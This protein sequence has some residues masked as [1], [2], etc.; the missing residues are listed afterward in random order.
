MVTRNEYIVSLLNLQRE[1]SPDLPLTMPI[2][3]LVHT[4]LQNL[5]LISRKIWIVLLQLW[6][7]W[8][9]SEWRNSR[10]INE[11]WDYC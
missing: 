10:I 11:K 2:N 1:L 9:S 3:H 6:E 4:N 7:A 8:T 5:K